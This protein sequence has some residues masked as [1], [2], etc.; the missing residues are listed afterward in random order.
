MLK[1]YK[2]GDI[3]RYWEAW[4]T[5]SEVTIHWGILG[6][7][8]ETREIQ[9]RDGDNPNEI[10]EREAREPKKQGYKKIPASKLQRLIIQYP[11]K[12]MGATGDL[13]KR[14]Q[15]EEL[16]NECL[17]WKGLGHCDGG[18]MGSGTMNI[19]CF[20]VDAKAAVPH[21]LQELKQNELL[22]EALVATGDQPNVVWPE[23][24]AGDFQV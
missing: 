23:N 14:V 15:V 3:A 12:G 20:V 18:D 17:G 10:I 11:I 5:A 2:T 24:F 1:L 16:M 6:E 19:F 22:E 7:K 21:V 13:D 4:S 9:I 8:G